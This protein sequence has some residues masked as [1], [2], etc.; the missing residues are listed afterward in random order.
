EGLDTTAAFGASMQLW[1]YLQ[2]PAFAI[3]SAV[4]AMG[5]Q[6][7]GAG[8]HRRVGAVTLFGVTTNL[9]MTGTLGLLIVTFDRPLLAVFLGPGSPA[10]PI[11]R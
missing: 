6:A 10:I 11:A 2:M 1:N 9:A 8:N 7:I 5:A 4:S 3:G